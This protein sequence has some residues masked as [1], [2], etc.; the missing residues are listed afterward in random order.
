MQPAESHAPALTVVGGGAWGTALAQTLAVAGK[1]QP[2]QLLVRTSEQA[3]LM[4]ETRENPRYL[5]GLRLHPAIMPHSD[6]ALVASSEIVVLVVP[7]QNLR[8][9]LDG[10]GRHLHPQATIILAI[11]GLEKNSQRRMSEIVAEYLPGHPLAV[12]SGPSFAHEVMRGLPCSLVLAAKNLDAATALLPIFTTAS[13]RL[14]P[15]S[16]MVGVELGG[17]VKNV[18]AIACGIAAGLCL[19]ENAR[20]ALITRGLAEM[21]RLGLAMGAA[22]KTLSG[23]SGLGDLVLTCG[24]ETS[25][26]FRFG[27]A[28]G[29]GENARLAERRIGTVEGIHT[30]DAVVSLAAKYQ[31]DT[32]ISQAVQRI[33]AEEL[34]PQAAVIGLM[35]RDIRNQ[36]E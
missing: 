36:G 7:G 29:G 12:L 16:D 35:T 1:Y 9:C 11:K 28:L 31:V 5:P 3:R 13:M 8:D 17:A 21:M 4:M 20:A 30:V 2:I 26:N 25:R 22:G 19:G 27:L 23:L 33:M 24:G 34:S 14:Y 18:L 10:L 32:P 6:P 15:S